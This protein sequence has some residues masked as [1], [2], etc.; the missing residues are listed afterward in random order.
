MKILENLLPYNQ[1]SEI[2]TSKICWFYDET[3]DLIELDLETFEK[4]L[5]RLIIPENNI[6]ERICICQLPGN[7]LFCYGN[8]IGWADFSGITFIFNENYEVQVLPTGTPSLGCCGTYYKDCVYVFGGEFAERFNIDKWRW[9]KLIKLPSRTRWYSSTFLNDILL[10]TGYDW[11]KIFALDLFTLSFSS[12]P[13]SLLWYETK[14]LCNFEDSAYLIDYPGKIFESGKNDPFNWNLIGNFAGSEQ[15]G[16]I[17]RKAL[18]NKAWYFL[19]GD[20]EIIKFDLEE[21]KIIRINL[22]LTY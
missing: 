5:H 4:T 6:D 21:K 13:I 7:K 10:V 22:P 17:G 11:D 18:Y 1:E 3:S 8:T 9:E 12:C 19:T 15:G 20:S 14:F 16:I 2:E